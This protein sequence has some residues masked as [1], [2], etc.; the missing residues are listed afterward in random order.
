MPRTS[1][2]SID[3]PYGI[4]ADDRRHFLDIDINRDAAA[5]YDIQ[6][7]DIQQEISSAIGGMNVGT[8][9]EGLERYP[10]SVRYPRELRESL[11]AMKGILVRSPMGHFVPL[12]EL[13]T[14]RFVKGPPVIKSE[15]AKPT[16]WIY[17]DVADSDIG[18]YVERARRVVDEDIELAPG[19]RLVWSGQFEYVRRVGTPVA[20]MDL[21]ATAAAGTK[22]SS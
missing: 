6:V 12:G 7:D 14:L 9:V 3:H 1:A 8:T 13:A 18:G 15:G 17:V 2:G 19:Y 11:E 22:E 4:C 10:I 5:R 21:A 16:A 20:C